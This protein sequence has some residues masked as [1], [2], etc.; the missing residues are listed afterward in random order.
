MDGDSNRGV[1]SAS[2][3]TRWSARR[4]IRYQNPQATS[5]EIL[6]SCQ[7]ASPLPTLLKPKICALPCQSTENV[8]RPKNSHQQS[9]IHL[10]H[11]LWLTISCCVLFWL[12]V[13]VIAAF[14]YRTKQER[15]LRV[16]WLRADVFLKRKVRITCFL[17]FKLPFRLLTIYIPECLSSQ[18]SLARPESWNEKTKVWQN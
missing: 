18:P 2:S 4:L 1:P 15:R 17:V 13:C 5:G 16:S 6:P 7:A 9:N 8:T 14:L 3:H 10:F 12:L 11:R